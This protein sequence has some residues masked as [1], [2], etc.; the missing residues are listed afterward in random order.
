MSSKKTFGQ[1]MWG[2]ERNKMTGD[3]VKMVAGGIEIRDSE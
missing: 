3:G 1:K 2:N